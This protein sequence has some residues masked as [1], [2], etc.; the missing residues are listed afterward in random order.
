MGGGRGRLDKSNWESLREDAKEKE[1]YI[2]EEIEEYEL[3][4]ERKKEYSQ[5]AEEILRYFNKYNLKSAVSIG[6]GKGILEWHLKKKCP[7]IQI[8]CTDYTEKALNKLQRVFPDAEEFYTFDMAG[9]D[10]ELLKVYDE[11]ILFRVSTEFSAKK[12]K[13]IFLKCYNAGIDRVVF[14]PGGVATYKTIFNEL[15]RHGINKIRNQCDT[16]CGW[17][18]TEKE[19]PRMWKGLYSIEETTDVGFSKIYFLSRL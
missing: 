17:I 3:N 14:C 1:F 10:W 5:A 8:S 13:E 2:E 15:K 9:Q 19:F 7:S 4:C 16:F 6:V 12:W 11:V 18:Y